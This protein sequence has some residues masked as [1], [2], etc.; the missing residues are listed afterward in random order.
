MPSDHQ[1]QATHEADRE[2][3]P[4]GRV[5]E[6]AFGLRAWTRGGSSALGLHAG[7]LRGLG[8]DGAVLVA[9]RRSDSPRV[10]G[11]L[12]RRER[13]PEREA[14]ASQPRRRGGSGR[15]W[16]CCSAAPSSWSAPTTARAPTCARAATPTWPRWSVPRPSGTTSS[17]QRVAELND[18]VDALSAR[19]V[20]DRSVNRVP[21]ARSSG[22]RPRRPD[23]ARRARASPSPSPTPP[24]TSSTP[25]TGMTS[26]C[27]SCTS[28]TSRPS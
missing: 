4:T 26:T 15:R 1:H 14:A 25:P 16:W 28:R 11:Y 21:A 9:R 27:W 12:S 22:W 2:H 7:L 8:G 18:E 13:D 24:R 20:D 6:V 19:S 5:V 3:R 10:P 17:Q 23:P